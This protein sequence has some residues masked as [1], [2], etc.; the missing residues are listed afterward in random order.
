MI[1][2]ERIVIKR[3][4]VLGLLLAA[5]LSG[6]AAST[7]LPQ[8]YR[9]WLALV[10][11]I[12][13]SAEREVFLQLKTDT[14]R[15]K[16][17]RLFWKQRDPH[18]DT[19]ENEFYKDYMAR[20]DFADR[21]FGIGSHK[22]GHETER[23]YYYLVLGPPLERQRFATQS[24]VWPLELWFYKGE[25]QYG[26][27]D[28]FYLIF[29]QPEGIGDYRLYYPGIEGPEKLVVPS[30][31]GAALQRTNA[32]QIVKKVSS[33]LA[34]AATSYVAGEKEFGL[35]SLSSEAI[36]A[37]VK[38]LKEKKFSDAYARSY[39]DFKDFVETEYSDRFLGCDFKARPFRTNGQTFLH[40]T[41]EPERIS[42]ELRA[43]VYLAQFE[44]SLRLED[45]DGQLVYQT[46]EEI[47]LR[48]NEEQYRS[49]ERRRLAFQDVLPV[50]AG[51]FQLHLLLKNKTG[52]DFTSAEARVVV[53]DGAGSSLGDLLLSHGAQ[54]V[55]DAER[56]RLKPFALGGL[57]F[58]VNA[59]DE[60]IPP[61]T[62]VCFV[63]GAG[64]EELAGASLHF[65]IFG[66]DG[67]AAAR[68]E[69]KPLKD[70]LGPDGG[71][72]TARFDLAGIKPGYYEARAWVEDGEG[73]ISLV[74]KTPFVLLAQPVP[75][76]PWVLA[77]VR[78]AFPN[79]DGLTVLATQ[80]F[81][82]RHYDR[83]ASRLEQALALRDGPATRLLFAKTLYALDRFRDSLA[84]AGPL[85]E[86]NG[87]REAA[88][89]I[90]LDLAGLKDW[91]G[92]LG[93]LEKLLEGATEIGVLNL[94]GE[95]LIELGRAPEA[96]PLLE[97]SLSLVPGQ[98]AVRAL[99]DRA[100]KAP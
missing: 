42:F 27:P 14:D 5:A 66:L 19:P 71:L 61:E 37:G 82:L 88:K 50:V 49:H 8:T 41:L 18:P 25:T 28:Y 39:L 45:P 2:T 55:P 77:K 56:S 4:F 92:A 1:E 26:L 64:L 83:A 43:G 80:D 60:F 73:R 24:E 54:P 12:L 68:T 31:Y 21:N 34:S 97:K 35:S 52:H 79:P 93:Y 100:R 32:L 78:D 75:V 23:G 13:T 96:I 46:Q 48:L 76:M 70:A 10:D 95:C 58:A 53:P 9:D 11:P 81:M 98:P 30:L 87:D 67:Q 69:P 33:E 84:A 17:I 91:A 15:E 44:L 99:L 22:P 62:L 85:F 16:F 29:Y 20:V 63:Q 3:P 47:P 51:T 72:G 7:D 36:I 40:W 59:R 90:A 74:A 65:G 86:A 38:G 6:R 89:V 94:A 57:Q